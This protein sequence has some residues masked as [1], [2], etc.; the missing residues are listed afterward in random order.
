MAANLARKNEERDRPVPLPVKTALSC[1]G[2]FVDGVGVN[3]RLAFVS[4]SAPLKPPA[5]EPLSGVRYMSDGH[6]GGIRGRW[7][8][9]LVVI[10]ASA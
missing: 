1:P 5:R 2:G 3:R 9:G 10:T 6:G 4:L 8:T 7:M